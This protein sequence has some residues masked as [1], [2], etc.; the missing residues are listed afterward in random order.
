MP[1][2]IGVQKVQAHDETGPVNPNFVLVDA[3]GNFFVYPDDSNGSDIILLFIELGGGSATATIATQGR[4]VYNVDHLGL[5]DADI[6]V[7]IAQDTNH[8][9]GD[10]SVDRFKDANGRCNISYSGTLTN[11]RVACLQAVRSQ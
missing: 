2:Q 4:C 7:S 3:T 1:T 9:V 11:L 6:A 10:L 8:A 5:G